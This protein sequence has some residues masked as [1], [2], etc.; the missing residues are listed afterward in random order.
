MAACF[1]TASVIC[2]E[3][4]FQVKNGKL[5]ID[6]LKMTNGVT[7]KKVEIKKENEYEVKITHEGGIGRVPIELLPYKMREH[8]QYDIIKAEKE[9][10]SV[11]AARRRSVELTERHKEALVN[12][13]L[14]LRKAQEEGPLADHKE[15]LNK[16]MRAKGQIPSLGQ[17]NQLDEANMRG[18]IRCSFIYYQLKNPDS[19]HFK[20][21]RNLVTGSG[22]NYY[23]RASSEGRFMNLAEQSYFSLP[24]RMRY[25]RGKP[26]LG[27]DTPS[28][29][30]P[31]VVLGQGTK[32]AV[33][34][35]LREMN[36]FIIF[37]DIY[38]RCGKDYFLK[39][40]DIPERANT[41]D[42][43]LW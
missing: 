5:I 35:N 26:P 11:L 34:Q 3:G 25:I 12:E 2:A 1:I 16:I 41:G 27:Y 19:A 21:L 42:L 4:E 13:E 15:F 22:G 20:A 8:F 7:Y 40:G 10:E 38:S 9:R 43:Y 33:T 39:G 29:P 17:I 14:S 37:C 31:P 30:Y 28:K 23:F 6:H 18:L 32:A 36:F 24:P